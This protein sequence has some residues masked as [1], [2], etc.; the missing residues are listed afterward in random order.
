MAP[1]LCDSLVAGNDLLWLFTRSVLQPRRNS[2]LSKFRFGTPT[3]FLG[4]PQYA[5]PVA[6]FYPI[7][8]LFAWS[9]LPT[10][11]L[12][13]WLFAFHIGLAAAG[14]FVLARQDGVGRPGA[15]ARWPAWRLDGVYTGAPVC[16]AFAAFVDAGLFAVG[17]RCR[18]VGSAPA[19]LVSA[20]V[21]AVPLALGILAG[22]APFMLYLVG[23]LLVWMV[24][25]GFWRCAM[26]VGGQHCAWLVRLS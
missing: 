2:E 4:F 16:R 18:T 7:W 24:W 13:T 22:Y 21:A 12:L 5:E 8:W 1:A 23:G 26:P 6:A 9:P 20:V 15:F 17:S 14:V 19:F 3:I 10:A 11:Q 25:L